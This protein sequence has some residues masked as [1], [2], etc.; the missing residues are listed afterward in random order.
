V[1]IDRAGEPNLADMAG[2]TAGRRIHL[3]DFSYTIQAKRLSEAN[4]V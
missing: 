3:C 4:F 1:R 2:F